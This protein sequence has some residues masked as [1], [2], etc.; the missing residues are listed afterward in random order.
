MEVCRKRQREGDAD[1]VGLLSPAE[2]LGL[3]SDAFEP[4]V[5]LPVNDE[6]REP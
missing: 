3:P 1:R 5:I 4:V 2:R 6:E